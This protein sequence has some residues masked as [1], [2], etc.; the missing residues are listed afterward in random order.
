MPSKQLRSRSVIV[1]RSRNA[2]AKTEQRA[3][4]RGFV[5]RSTGDLQQKRPGKRPPQEA[6]QTNQNLTRK[7]RLKSLT[8]SN[9]DARTGLQPRPHS[10]ARKGGQYPA[11]GPGTEGEQTGPGRQ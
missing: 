9:R 7:R 11:S 4:K 3:N 10:M 1:I 5:L 8:A 2:L 6:G